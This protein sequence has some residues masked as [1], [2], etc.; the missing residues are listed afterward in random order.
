[1][2]TEITVS[3][4]DCG[5]ENVVETEYRED[6][7]L[8]SILKIIKPVDVKQYIFGGL[9]KCECGKF[10]MVTLNVVAGPDII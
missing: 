7:E 6:K 9:K 3:C 2:K 4:P 1:M 5:R 10:I 8:E